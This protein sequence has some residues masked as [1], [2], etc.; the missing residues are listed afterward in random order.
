VDFEQG[1][2]EG[3]AFF[4]ICKL[5]GILGDERH[6]F[7]NCIE[8]VVDEFGGIFFREAESKK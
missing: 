2:A 5:F 3:N 7:D 4:A 8:L 6:D 1:F